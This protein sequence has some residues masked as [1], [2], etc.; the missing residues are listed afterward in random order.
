MS[1]FGAILGAM[2]TSK[3]FLPPDRPQLETGFAIALFLAVVRLISMHVNFCYQVAQEKQ[4]F[5][6]IKVLT[7]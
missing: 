7:N 4:L 5:G 2:G 1:P 6:I 3:G